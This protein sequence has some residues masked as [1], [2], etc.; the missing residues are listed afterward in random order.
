MLP[1]KPCLI[2]AMLAIGSISLSQS[3]QCATFKI[4]NHP[5]IARDKNAIFD[6]GEFY[7][8][9]ITE[10][11]DQTWIVAQVTPGVSS[12]TSC[13]LQ[14]YLA[15]P[16]GGKDVHAEVIPGP[17]VIQIYGHLKVTATLTGQMTQLM[18]K[19]DWET[20]A[21]TFMG[22]STG[23]GVLT[24]D[25]RWKRLE[26]NAP[27]SDADAMVCRFNPDID[28][29]TDMEHVFDP[30]V[31]IPAEWQSYVA[32]ALEFMQQHPDLKIDQPSTGK[33]GPARIAELRRLMTDTNPF[34]AGAACRQLAKTG[35]LDAA[36]VQAALQGSS[37]L[38][39]A[40]FTYLVVEDAM[41]PGLIAAL[42]SAIDGTISSEQRQGIA[43]GIFTAEEQNPLDGPTSA[44][45][46]LMQRIAAREDAQSL[47][48]R[49][50][51]ESQAV[52]SAAV[53]AHTYLAGIFESDSGL[54]LAGSK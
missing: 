48:K 22:S 45:T 9:Q 40:L 34:L 18:W 36:S 29:K 53:A 41:Q 11:S 6:V 38:R 4:R 3:T 43:L 46:A 37:G 51:G 16:M 28:P 1:R 10:P 33:I 21:P 35:S 49:P 14:E 5:S 32:P 39:Q 19:Y 25:P 27:F 47:A 50:A 7:F 42:K 24:S 8:N 15:P 30:A 52:S 13:S 20:P 12:G 17:P 31:A 26:H 44:Q 2:V 23:G 54:A